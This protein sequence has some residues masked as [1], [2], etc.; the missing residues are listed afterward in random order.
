MKSATKF[1]V[2]ILASIPTLLAQRTTQLT[3]RI[4]DATAAVIPGAEITVTSED[5]GIR[6][7]TTSNE[8]GY[9]VV[10]LLQPGRYSVMVQKAGLR[11]IR[12][13]GITLEVDQ[14]ARLDFVME[15]G[16]VSESIQVSANVTLVD[17]QSSTLKSV[18]DERRIKELPLNGRDATQLVL[19]LPGVY[20]TV[21]DNSGL[22]QAGSGR[23]I[24]QAGVASNGARGNMVN[25][26][27]DGTTHNDTYTNVALAF[28]NPDAL[29]EFS[30]QTNNFSAE[31]GRSAGAVVTAVTKS[32]T[33]SLHGSLFEFHRNGAVNARNFFAPRPDGLKR[34]QF[35]GTVGGPIWKDHTFFF[36]SHQETRQRSRPSDATTTVLTE[37]QRRGD[38]SAFSG[39]IIDPATGQPFPGKQ[40]P[41]TRMNP[42]TKTILDKLIPLPTE[43]A[44]GLLRY[45]VPASSD[46]RQSVLKI[47]HQFSTKDTLSGRYLYNYYSE[48][49]NDVALV[50]ATRGTRT[51]PNHN[52]EFT[53]THVFS[54]TLMNQ[55]Q[56][57]F[58]RR[59]DVGT[60]VWTT[61]F[62]D[63]GMRNVFTDTPYKN[64]NLSVTGAFSASVTEAIRTQ[65]NA[66]TIADNLRWTKGRHEMSM[67][68]EYRKQSLDKNF[69]WLLDPAMTF[70]ASIT[71][72]GVADFFIGRPSLLDQMAYGEVGVQDFPVYIAFFQ[73][74]IKV[75]PKLTVNVGLRYEPSIPYR[76][77]GNRVSVFR[78]GLKSQ[79]FVNAPT[80]LLF[81]GDPGVPERGTK[82]DM[83]NFAP[84]VGF[85]WAPANRTSIRAAYG[86]FYDSS[87]MS[88]ITNVF[89]G[90]A[91]FGTRLRLRPPPG[92]FDDPFLGAN[93]FP[94]QFPPPKDIAFPNGVAAAT[95]P[96]Q[97]VTGYLQSWHFTIERELIPNW[98][99][100]IAYAGSKGTKLLQGEELNPPAY[101]PGQSTA[102]N[103][104]QRRPYGPAL[105]TIR[106]VNGTGSSNFNSMQLSVDKRFSKGMTLQAN[107]TWGKSIDYGS[108]GGTQWPSFTPGAPW[109]DRGLSDFH[110]EHRFVASGLWELPSLTGTMPL[111][112]WV[113]GGWQ[114][115]GS[116]I[117][118]SAAAFS[119][120]AGRDNSLTGFGNRAQQ[121]GDPSRSARQDPNRDPVL[122]WFN[123]RAFVHNAPGTYGNSGR[124][125]VFGPG[126][127]NVDLS[128]AK[129][130][131]VSERVRL[132]VRGEFFNLFNHTNFNEPNST[133][134][135][136]TYGRITS[137]LD[138]RIL[139]FGLKLV[140]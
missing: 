22:R 36:F 63:L 37:A 92:P 95:W 110:H 81:V 54:P 9:F 73:D 113:L 99:F 82:S 83:N 84:R 68:F 28:P 115:S 71:G 137:A 123:T 88:A 78:P 53:Q 104:S 134:T 132:Q 126:L 112:K 124:N 80:G 29:Q 40:I 130:F 119:V 25:Y 10:P 13:S 114:T 64:F 51:T 116:M 70:D 109:Y 24:V 98:L 131:S 139:Q 90:V 59:E 67:G 94:M 77:E 120:Q 32:G 47:D 86:I 41:I 72:Y 50:F 87:P 3:G 118:Q 43:P 45:S 58:T 135:A 133:I 18:V 76:D 138:P 121:V 102:A 20:G 12:Q 4:T 140:F 46:L 7:D 101:I 136:A 48:P 27:L 93:P 127:A 96:E 74:N 21:R 33:N 26:T 66:Y 69:R 91:P 75:T 23:G 103:I 56:Y 105:D 6:R 5:T 128:V 14:A 106:L 129:F 57:S 108:G 44:T 100:R 60:P 34:H 65:P 19:L 16:S 1:L 111:V 89:Q 38:F 122:E 15:V 2:L 11:P 8:L 55:A 49:A 117:L 61:G 17:T 97:Y 30:V 107:Y 52:L 62:A 39:N 35:G 125:I 85:A 42:L 79:V 31:S